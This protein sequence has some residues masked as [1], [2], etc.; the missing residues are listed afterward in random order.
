MPGTLRHLW[1]QPSLVCAQGEKMAGC[2]RR[3]SFLT[4]LFSPPGYL[5]RHQ[6]AQWF[7]VSPIYQG[8]L[9]TFSCLL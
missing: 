8:M 2:K 7:P 1:L 6:C 4:P 9:Q 3:G 5:L